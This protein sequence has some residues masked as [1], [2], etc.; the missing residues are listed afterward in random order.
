MKTKSAKKPALIGVRGMLI[1]NEGK[2]RSMI[3]KATNPLKDLRYIDDDTGSNSLSNAGV[4]FI[5]TLPVPPRGDAQLG[6][7]SGDTIFIT[8]MR[9][10][11]T[12]EGVESS[13]GLADIYNRFAWRFFWLKNNNASGTPPAITGGAEAIFDTS[14]T[15]GSGEALSPWGVNMKNRVS[16]IKEGKGLVVGVDYTVATSNIQFVKEHVYQRIITKTFKRPVKIV[17]SASDSDLQTTFIGKMP[18]F[19]AISDSTAAS[20]PTIQVQTRYFYYS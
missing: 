1:P 11:I 16:T 12:V 9:M 8:K 6:N 19:S 5:G 2:V 3:A 17:F 15:S 7:R 18:V 14:G 20:H 4:I 10:I 13:A